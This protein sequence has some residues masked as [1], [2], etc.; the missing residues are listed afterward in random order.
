[1][2]KQKKVKIDSHWKHVLEDYSIKEI[3]GKGSSGEVAR[4]KRR[5]TG[6][7]VAIKMIR[8]VN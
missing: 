1:M 6:E 2:E 8:G 3:I 5:A 7:E 4:A